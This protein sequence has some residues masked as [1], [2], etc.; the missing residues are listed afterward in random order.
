LNHFTLGRRGI[1]KAFH[2]GSPYLVDAAAAIQ[3]RNEMVGR[4]TQTKVATVGRVLQN[5]P[6]DAA[7]C[8]R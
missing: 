5:K 6:L 4:I 8:C 2:A 7:K 3:H 1:A